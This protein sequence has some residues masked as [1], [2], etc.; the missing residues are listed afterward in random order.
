MPDRLGRILQQEGAAV[1]QGSLTV[2][3]GV[4]PGSDPETS[5][6]ESG[7]AETAFERAY[8]SK[9]PRVYGY[10]RYRVGNGDATDDLTSRT[11]LKALDRLSTFDSRKADIGPWILGIARNVVRDHLRAGRRWGW[12]PL[13]W[14]WDRP[15]PGPTPEQAAIQNEQRQRLLGA[16]RAL[17]ERERDL[18]GLKFAGGLTN[19]AIAQ[20]TGLGES[21]VGVIVYRAVGRLRARLGDEEARRA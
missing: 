13:D 15:A 19:R 8:E 14:L 10:I 21:H 18:L 4:R 7:D 9:F 1:L 3:Q 12:L 20:L 16:L 6:Q 5:A 11:F 2:S 17:S